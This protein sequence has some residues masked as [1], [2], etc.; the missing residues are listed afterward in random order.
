M[1]EKLPDRA[2]AL[3]MLELTMLILFFTVFIGPVV[4]GIAMLCLF[5]YARIFPGPER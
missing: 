2:R 1:N 4:S 3:F 5:C